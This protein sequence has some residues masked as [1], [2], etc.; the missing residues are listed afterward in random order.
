LN[1]CNDF[2][3][4]YIERRGAETLSLDFLSVFGALC[5]YILFKTLN[6]VIL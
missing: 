5:S 3:D 6:V 1:L 2:G 4:E